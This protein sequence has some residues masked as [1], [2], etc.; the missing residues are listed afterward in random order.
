VAF[1]SWIFVAWKLCLAD[2]QSLWISS[3]V[4]LKNKQLSEFLPLQNFGTC[5]KSPYNLYKIEEIN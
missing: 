3:N 5:F 1:V 4:R 2:R